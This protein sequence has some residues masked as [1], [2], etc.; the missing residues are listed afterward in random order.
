MTDL[1]GKTIAGRYHVSSLLGNGDIAEVYKV[2]DNLRSTNLA[3]KVIYDNFTKDSFFLKK[4]QREA[5]ALSRIQ[6]PNIARFYGFEQTHNLVYFLMELIEGITLSQ[7]IYE[8][9]NAFSNKEIIEIM[10]P[11]CSAL[12]CIHS[13]GCV[14]LGIKPANILIKSGHLYISGFCL[15]QIAKTYNTPLFSAYMSPEQMRGDII[16]SPQSDIYSLGLVLFEILTCGKKPFTGENANHK[17][18]IIENIKY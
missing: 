3:M 13:S 5:H 2:W 15:S 14:H 1:T 8:T 16:S 12:Q 6:H 9:K 7:R 10:R 18:T 4:L 17:G 11:M